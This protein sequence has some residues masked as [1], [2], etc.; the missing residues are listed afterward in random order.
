MIDKKKPKSDR[1]VDNDDVYFG[2]LDNGDNTGHH[3]KKK[4]SEGSGDND[5]DDRES[6][7][8]EQDE[9]F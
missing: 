2:F 5:E 4:S 9:Y 7:S 6:S 1:A 3:K 8:S